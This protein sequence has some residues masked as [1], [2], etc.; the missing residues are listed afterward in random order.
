MSRKQHSLTVVLALIA[1]LVGGVISSEFFMGRL[2]YAEKKPTQ[3][4]VV[5]AEKFELVDKNN[6]VVASALYH[7]LLD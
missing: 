3:E 5:R 4:K 6:K 7:N 1:G 2:V